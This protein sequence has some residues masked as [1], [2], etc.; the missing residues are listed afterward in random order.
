MQIS[1]NSFLI[2]FHHNHI[3]NFIRC[4]LRNKRQL[5]VFYKAIMTTSCGQRESQ[6]WGWN[7]SVSSCSS[8]SVNSSLKRTMMG[9]FFMS[10]HQCLIISFVWGFCP[11]RSSEASG[12][13][14]LY[15]P[16]YSLVPLSHP[17]K[18]GV[19][20]KASTAV[21]GLDSQDHWE[22]RAIFK[23]APQLPSEGSGA[24]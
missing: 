2:Q 1:V 10:H 16:T 12:I 13:L 11:S 4:Q 9:S 15:F 20:G 19:S 18:E 5:G 8:L 3:V 23:G 6:L 22:A 14:T 17:L 7:A 21:S 24:P